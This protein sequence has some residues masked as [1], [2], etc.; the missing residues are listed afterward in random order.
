MAAAAYYYLRALSLPLT[1][2]RCVPQPLL[3]GAMALAHPLL[4]LAVLTRDFMLTVAVESVA[5]AKE[6]ADC[7]LMCCATH[8]SPTALVSRAGARSGVAPMVLSLAV[9]TETALGYSG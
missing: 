8:C 9:K 7:P 4:L 3:S 2:T 1:A 6:S 5:F